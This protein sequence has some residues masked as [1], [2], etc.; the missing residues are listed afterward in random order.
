MDDLQSTINNIECA[1]DSIEL[2]E[3]SGK[4]TVKS[5][6][7]SH[8]DMSPISGRLRSRTRYGNCYLCN[9]AHAISVLR[10]SVSCLLLAI[11]SIKTIHC[12]VSTAWRQT[13]S[14]WHE[15]CPVEPACRL[16]RRSRDLLASRDLG[17][18]QLCATSLPIAIGS[19]KKRLCRS[20]YNR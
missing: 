19:P 9:L 18:D 8:F 5:G 4:C 2:T 1:V 20:D 17:K 3:V 14:Q 7:I 16:G 13:G 15:S 11:S 12:S 6:R 10:G